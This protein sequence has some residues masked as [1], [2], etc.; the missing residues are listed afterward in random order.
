MARTALRWHA[1]WLRVRGYAARTAADGVVTAEVHDRHR[2]VERLVPDAEA[3]PRR[4]DRAA[5]AT[6][7]ERGAWLSAVTTR[8]G[9]LADR[10]VEHG[11]RVLAPEECVMRRPLAGHPAPDLP[12]G[13]DLALDDA[14]PGVLRV[15]VGAPDGTLAAS[16]QAGLTGDGAVVA[17]RILTE[18]GHRRQGLGSAVMGRL[19]AAAV[20]QGASDGLLVASP[21]GRA[22]YVTLGWERVADLVVATQR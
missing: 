12:A 10:L 19:A 1:G 8:P 21:E 22:L 16:G 11:L 3:D 13:Y 20:A 2:A 18:P 7:A 4:L 6:L 15:R 14:V 5:Q 9:H 17:D